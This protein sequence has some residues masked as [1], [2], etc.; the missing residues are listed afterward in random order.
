MSHM[1]IH[2]GGGVSGHLWFLLALFWVF[3]VFWVIRKVSFGSLGTV[4]LLSLTVQF[5]HKYLPF[6]FFRFQQGMEYIIW[7]CIGYIFQKLRNDISIT[8]FGS[9]TLAYLATA[10][11]LIE[12][13]Y[14]S[15][16]GAIRI[17]VRSFWIYSVSVCI[18]KLIPS[19]SDKRWYQ[20][21]LRNCFYIYIFHDPL[22]YVVLRI[23]FEHSWLTSSAGCYAY[24]FCRT[25]GVVIVSVMLGEAVLLVKKSLTALLQS[26]L[27]IRQ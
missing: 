2:W 13:K 26:R 4:F 5:Y 7:F 27:I 17:L 3:I 15:A 25:A 8:K 23:T 11:M 9:I 12:T 19:L 10:A 18:L 1:S 21:L 22:E 14:L 6:N 16:N 20:L 24:L